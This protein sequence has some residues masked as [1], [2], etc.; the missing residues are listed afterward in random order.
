MYSSEDLERFYFQ[1]QRESLPKGESVQKF[2]LKNK[3]LC[4]LFWICPKMRKTVYSLFS[5][6]CNQSRLGQAYNGTCFGGFF[7]NSAGVTRRNG[8][9]YHSLI[10]TVKLH[11]KSAWHYLGSFFTKSFNG[12][13]DFLSLTRGISKW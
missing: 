6:L 12:C 10:S 3:V 2:S 13:R 4:V 1:Y 5:R 7:E 8:S 11:E 9:T